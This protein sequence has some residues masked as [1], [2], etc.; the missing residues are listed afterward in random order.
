MIL[1]PTK[2]HYIRHVLAAAGEKPHIL[3]YCCANVVQSMARGEK[4]KL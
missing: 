3:G 1:G 2:G 4:V